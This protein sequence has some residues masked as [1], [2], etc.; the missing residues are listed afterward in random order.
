MAIFN[1]YKRVF[2]Q[3][4][5]N[6]NDVEIQKSNILM[7]GA[8]GSGK[9]YL[10]RTIAKMLDVPL[11]VVDVSQITAAGYVGTSVEDILEQLLN[12]A[13][14]N[15]EIAERGIIILDEIDKIKRSGDS[16][17][18]VNG[19][20]A[21]NSILKLIEGSKMTLEKAQTVWGKSSNVVIDTTNILFVC[22]GSFAG[23]EDIIA[24]RLNKK[25]IGFGADKTNV[26]T[27]STLIHKVQQ[28]D[29]QKFGLVRELIGRLQIIVTLDTLDEQALKKILTEPKNALIKQYQ[30][31]FKFDDITLQ[32]DDEAIQKIASI[33]MKRK[34]G[35]RGLKSVLEDSLLQPMYELPGTE[36]KEYVVHASDILE[37]T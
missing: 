30:Q 16:G 5:Q 29:L 34:T 14:G 32:F 24:T 22:S 27:D 26:K 31:L 25:L 8:T 17:K 33:A 1:H 20:D 10:I 23:I 11:I 19:A 28:Q 9:T 15:I 2:K 21:Q 36:V 12:A 6:S 3:D 18:D 35:A 13:D 37:K 4:I 7:I